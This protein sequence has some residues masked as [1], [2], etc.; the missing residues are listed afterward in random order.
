MAENAVHVCVVCPLLHDGIDWVIVGIRIR[1]LG[2]MYEGTIQP[3][4]ILLEIRNWSTGRLP[5]VRLGY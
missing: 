4:R 3:T 2:M 1:R 5:V